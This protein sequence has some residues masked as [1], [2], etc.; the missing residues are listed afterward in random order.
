MPS[1][2]SQDTLK[3]LMEVESGILMIHRLNDIQ[4]LESK[5]Y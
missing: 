1:L 3:Y 2:I 5:I 4:L